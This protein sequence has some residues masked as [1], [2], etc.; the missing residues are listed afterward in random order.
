MNPPDSQHS[1]RG[2]QY[3]SL[4]PNQT[5]EDY[6]DELRSWKLGIQKTHLLFS[7][8]DAHTEAGYRWQLF[9]NWRYEAVRSGKCPL[10]FQHSVSSQ[11]PSREMV[12]QTFKFHQNL[13]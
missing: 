10:L 7:F 4:L 13:A 3:D 5:R 8:G 12:K 1:S 11:K 9:K 2:S 6:G